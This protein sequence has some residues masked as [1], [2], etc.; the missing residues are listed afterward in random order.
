MKIGPFFILF[1]LGTSR[2]MRVSGMHFIT[3]L[4]EGA[5]APLRAGAQRDRAR[6]DG[7]RSRV[8]MSVRVRRPFRTGP[9]GE[10]DDGGVSV[11]GRPARQ[12]VSSF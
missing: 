1:G 3:A 6:R 7:E 5:P 4:M 2:C 8:R 11:S 10:L 12:L 9:L